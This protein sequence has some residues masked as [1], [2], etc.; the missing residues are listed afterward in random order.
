MHYHIHNNQ[1][2]VRNNMVGGYFPIHDGVMK[3]G[4]VLGNPPQG[5]NRMVGEVTGG[6]IHHHQPENILIKRGQGL[7]DLSFKM[8]AAHGKKSRD[9]IKFIF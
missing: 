7:E 3:G 2:D 9:N 6:S 1:I 8:P 5:A 4:N